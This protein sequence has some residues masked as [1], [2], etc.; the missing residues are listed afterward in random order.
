MSVLP[1]SNRYT[2]FLAVVDAGELVFWVV[3]TAMLGPPLVGAGF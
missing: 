1:S 3:L 2:H